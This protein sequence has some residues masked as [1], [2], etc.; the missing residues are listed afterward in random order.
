MDWHRYTKQQKRSRALL[1]PLLECVFC[2]RRL[3]E[4]LADARRGEARLLEGG[5]DR[6]L[7]RAS[8]PGV[9]RRHLVEAHHRLSALELHAATGHARERLNGALHLGRACGA[10]HALYSKAYLGARRRRRRRRAELR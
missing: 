10:A 4:R 8:H 2:C 9:H 6:T 3:A 1:Y 7:Q 5:C